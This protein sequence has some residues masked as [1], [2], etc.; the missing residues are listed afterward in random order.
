M[1][2]ETKTDQA[3]LESQIGSPIVHGDFRL[4][5]VSIHSPSNPGQPLHLNQESVFQ[6]LN[7]FEDLFS[8]VLKGTFTFLDTQGWA[9]MIPL[10]GDETLVI[11]YSTPG[12][13]GTQVDTKSQD[14]DSQTASEEI[15]RQRFKVYDC[16]EVGTGERT[17]IYQLSLVS[18]EYM[19]S[20][21]MK[22]SKGYKGTKFG[23]PVKG[24]DGSIVGDI[25]KKLNKESEHLNKKLYIE[26]T[27]SPQN[28][29][30]PNWTPFQAINF[31]ASRSLSADI[32]P[33][34][35]DE[36]SNNPPPT[37]RPIGSL[38]VFYEKFGTGFFYESIE[39]MILKQKLKG[40]IPLYQYRP[41]VVE[42]SSL[43]PILQYF[44]VDKFEITGSFKT[45]E[46]MGHGMFGSHL[47]AYDPIRMKYEDVKY[48][49]YE[50]TADDVSET[51]N[52]KTDVTTTTPSVEQADDSQRVFSNF[53][54]TD[55]SA[56]DNKPN[57]LISSKSDY[58]GSN[59]ASIKL[60]TTTH[61]HDAMFVAPPNKTVIQ[62]STGEEIIVKLKSTIGVTKKT[63]KDQG[64]KQ[65]NVE[66]WLLQRQAQIS[67]F[68][69]IIV[70][71]TVAGNTSRHV[72]D[73][74]RFEVPSHI[75]QDS[76]E[77]GSVQIGH[78]L[79]SGYYLISKIRHIIKKDGFEMDLE[80][81][82][83][84]FAKRIP[85]QSSARDTLNEITVSAG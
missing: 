49:Y 34:E 14:L 74:I 84:S 66:N 73:L 78:Q 80:L 5:E 81:I 85:G 23:A 10:I 68:G 57:K 22:I 63:F 36:G 38:F 60:A 18:E 29:I 39:S 79:Y 37:T 12:G 53:I 45:L 32:E 51:H 64:A 69:N 17:K 62:Q 77:I 20:K 24:K 28:V 9:E 58:V 31:C 3:I 2:K 48:D 35:Q 65:N 72:G 61:A 82:K 19:Y 76:S 27:S 25:M 6:E 13:E 47:I 71:F 26:E 1:A 7:I 83:N 55:I 52:Q 40:N 30:I 15:T 50:K 46:N 44:S 11:S 42:G 21:K 4:Y 54:A 43:N 56:I 59:N 8:N 41:K 70:T 67:E 16:V 33:V 75:P